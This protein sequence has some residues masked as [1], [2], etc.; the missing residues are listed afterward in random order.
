MSLLSARTIAADV[1]RG[2]ITA[3]QTAREALDRI[4]A[5][6]AVQPQ[7]WIERPSA[8]MVLA[9]ARA[10]DA[11]VAAGQTPPLAGVPYAVKDNIDVAGMPTTAACPAFAYQPARSAAVIERLQ[12]AGAVMI[13]KTNLDQFATG[14]VGVR[15]PFGATECAY[16][17]AYISGGSSS[18]SAVAVAAG[19]VPF[20]LGSDTA[21]SGRVPAAIN[22]LIGLKPTRGR[23]STR[24]LVPA[25]RSLDCVSVFSRDAAD[26]ALVDSVLTGFDRED[27]YCRRAPEIRLKHRQGSTIICPVE[28]PAQTAAPRLDRKLIRAVSLAR[29]WRLDLERGAVPHDAGARATEGALSPTCGA[30][31]SA[32]LPRSGSRHDH[33]GGPSTDGNVPAGSHLQATAFGLARAAA[34]GRQLRLIERGAGFVAVCPIPVGPREIPCSTA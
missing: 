10:V 32:G 8:D 22:G 17:R 34:L 30:A 19:M 31:P 15:S 1:L 20:A 13:G 5:F 6:D 21:G 28:A 18:G 26:A 12:A 7:I 25:C 11:R 3:E 14:L 9:Q 29:Q 33:P 4:K 23:W 16:N 2:R 24:G 27:P